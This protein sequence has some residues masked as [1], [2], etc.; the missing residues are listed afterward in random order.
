MKKA[1]ARDTGPYL[2]PCR[3]EILVPTASQ[4]RVVWLGIWHFQTY[5]KVKYEQYYKQVDINTSLG[6]DYNEL[7]F[8]SF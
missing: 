6:L 4:T 5:G 8:E 2:Y 1:V 3:L 7:G